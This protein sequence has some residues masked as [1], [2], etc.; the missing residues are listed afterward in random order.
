MTGGSTNQSTG[1]I[2]SE[3]SGGGLKI[4]YEKQPPSSINLQVNLER[5]APTSTHQP[6][7][8]SR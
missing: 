8:R 5:I 2:T 4:T 7:K 3:M 1:V 6:A